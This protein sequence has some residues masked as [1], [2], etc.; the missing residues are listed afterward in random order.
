VNTFHTAA[1]A[2][3]APGPVPPGSRRFL[4]DFAGGDLAYYA[5]DPQLVEVVPTTSQGKILRSFVVPNPHVNGFRAI[6]DV[7]LQPKQSTDLRAFLRAGTQTLT[8]TWTYPWQ[9]D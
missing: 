3:G 7:E 4:I 5:R 2:L 6:I 8:E 9:A 1:A